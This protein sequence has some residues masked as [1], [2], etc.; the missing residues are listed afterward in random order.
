MLEI[1]CSFPYLAYKFAVMFIYDSSQP[2]KFCQPK[3]T[4][5][6]KKVSAAKPIAAS[7]IH[8]S[9]SDLKSGLC[10]TAQPKWYKDLFFAI[11]ITARP[12]IL[13]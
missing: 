6:L 5:E 2:N 3:R 8:A 7:R 13:Y 12:C 10:C 11:Q 1:N 4:G 9:N